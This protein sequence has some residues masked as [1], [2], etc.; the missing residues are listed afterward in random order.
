MKVKEE[1]EKT[2]LKLNIQKSNIMAIR[3]H[4]FMANTWGNNGNSERLYSG[5]LQY[6]CRWWCR[7]IDA[8]ELWC[9][10]SPLRVPWTARRSSH[11]ILKEISAEYSLKGLMLKLKFQYFD[12]LMQ[13]TDSLEKTLVGKDWR[14]GEKQT[15]EDEMVGWHHQLDGHESEQ[16]LEVGE[17][18]GSLVCCSP[19][20]HKE[21]D[22]TERLNR[23]TETV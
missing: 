4:N 1:S 6:H 20:G 9:W 18:Q 17:E 8:V 19:L 16:V 14:H 15:T 5:G 22:T 23:L 2:G 10:R 12:H 11:S 3:S 21:S 13:R 7:R